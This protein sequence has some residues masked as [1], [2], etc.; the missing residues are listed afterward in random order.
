[1]SGRPQNKPGKHFQKG[2]KGKIQGREGDRSPDWMRS[3][4]KFQLRT[5]RQRGPRLGWESFP[6]AATCFQG[7][8]SWAKSHA[9]LG[10]ASI[11]VELI[12]ALVW[13][14]EMRLRL[15]LP[16]LG[17]LMEPNAP[18]ECHHQHLLGEDK[19]PAR[20]DQ[21]WMLGSA[22][23]GLHQDWLPKTPHQPQIQQAGEV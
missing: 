20:W 16:D 18:S 19:P 8:A 12:P 5:K 11:P 3:W 14:Q 2:N 7:N 15:F 4:R 6:A 13:D 10:K 1:M 9:W 21:G 22:P 17:E 23:W